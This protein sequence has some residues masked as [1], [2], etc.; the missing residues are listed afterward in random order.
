MRNKHIFLFIVAFLSTYCFCFSQ[1][2][3]KAPSALTNWIDTQF[4][5]SLDSLHIPGATI[6]LVHGDSII[7]CKG[8]GL[9]D[10]EKK[11]PVSDSTLFGVASISKT[12]VGVSIMKLYEQG[13]LSLDKDINNY[14]TSI[15]VDYDYGRPITI[16][17]LLTHT[18]GIDESN[19]ANRV[20]TEKEFVPLA[21]F[22]RD[23]LP[24]QISLSG[25]VL[26]YSNY[27]YALLGLIIEDISGL[28]FDEYVRQNIL[29]PLEMNRSSFKRQSI[30]QKDYAKSYTL[31]DDVLFAYSKGFP[32]QYP[33]VSLDA[34]SSAM[35]NYISMLLKNGKYEGK[36]ILDSVTVSK[37]F[38]SA[39]KHYEKAQNG[40][41]YGF[42]EDYWKGLRIVQHDGDIDGFASTLVLIPEKELGMFIAI[43]ASSL[44]DKTNRHFIQKFVKNLLNKIFPKHSNSAI[45]NKKPQIGSVVKPLKSFSGA[46][47]HTRYANSTVEKLGLFIVIVPEID[48][49]LINDSILVLGNNER[50]IPISNLT[51]FAEKQAKYVAFKEN[52]DGDISYF[53]SDNQSFH[54][55]KWFETI[56]FH[57]WMIV[58]IVLVFIIFIFG[59]LIRQFFIIKRQMHIL[60]K[61]NI[62]ITFLSLLFLTTLGLVLLRTDPNDFVYGVPFILKVS[63]LIPPVII[64][65]VIWSFYL[66]I[67]TVLKKK[68]DFWNLNYLVNLMAILF[69]IWLGFWNLIG[70]NY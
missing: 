25:E 41:M 46:Y 52:E 59:C 19:L 49:G 44:T 50:L 3:I 5:K 43:N 18:A 16:C 32:L 15:K 66:L 38:T 53:F 55:L 21:Q 33:A 67:R 63:L 26:S 58:T 64:A 62:T 42:Y 8:Y 37:M 4:I 34:S 36:I 1:D 51:F 6:T 39:F 24:P 12:F 56:D 45:D 48:I 11:I 9:A 10:I 20:K 14:L 28:T 54:K 17:N 35:S 61:I 68:M 27:G 31:K 47:R 57:L 22:L 70:L 23:R 7:H 69:I 60:G 30:Y 29:R 2:L 13:K 65:L 40:W